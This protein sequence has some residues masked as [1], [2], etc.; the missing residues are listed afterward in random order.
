MSKLSNC[1]C[2]G[3]VKRSVD[4]LSRC[5]RFLNQF[6]IYKKNLHSFVFE[7]NKQSLLVNMQIIKEIKITQQN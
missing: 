7:R 1:N 3:G 4:D 6:E 5:R 2:T